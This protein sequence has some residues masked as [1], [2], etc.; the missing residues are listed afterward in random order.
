MK[1]RAN[2]G[3]NVSNTVEVLSEASEQT[4]KVQSVHFNRLKPQVFK[5]VYPCKTHVAE[6]KQ[7]DVVLQK[8]ALPF[9]SLFTFM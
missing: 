9:I 7:Y 6:I 3:L 2:P 4:P 8:L 1:R 5:H